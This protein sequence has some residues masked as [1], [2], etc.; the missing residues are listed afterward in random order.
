MELFGYIQFI[1]LSFIKVEMNYN[2]II[3]GKQ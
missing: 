1:A 3:K 2:I